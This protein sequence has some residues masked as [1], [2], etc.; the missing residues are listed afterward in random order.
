ME[1]IDEAVEL[2]AEASS[3]DT[4]AAKPFTPALANPDSPASASSLPSGATTPHN[5][6]VKKDD[7]PSECEPKFWS[8]SETYLHVLAAWKL[9][10]WWY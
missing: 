2:A 10:G 9:M 4:E 3:A 8:L 6:L 1:K 5:P 7:V